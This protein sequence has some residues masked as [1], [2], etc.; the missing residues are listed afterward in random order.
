MLRKFKQPESWDKSR[1]AQDKKSVLALSLT[2][3][4]NIVLHKTCKYCLQDD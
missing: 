3:Y 1:V 4:L 2:Q